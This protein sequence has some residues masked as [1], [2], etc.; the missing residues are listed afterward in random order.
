MNDGRQTDGDR[1]WPVRILTL[2]PDMITQAVSHSIIGRAGTAGLLDV[3]AVDIRDFT[4]DRHKTADDVPFGGGPGM[5]MK[6]EPLAGA[7]RAAKA[8]LPGAPVILMSASGRLF[9]QG[10]ARRFAG[11]PAGLIIVC[12]HYEGV[13]ERIAEFYC[14]EEICVGDYVLSGGEL[15]A[16]A[17][18]DAAARLI[19]GVLGNAD[20]LDE[21]SHD[22][23]CLEYPHYTRPRDFEGHQVPEVLFSGN[24]AAI[25]SFRRQQAA[26]KTARNR[27]DLARTNTEAP[28]ETEAPASGN[29]TA[30]AVPPGWGRPNEG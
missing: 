17:I 6:P 15:P 12:G 11:C 14:D 28:A 2:F 23:G 1:P 3:R 30:R 13:D 21:E 16:L 9:G 27:P 10:D 8:E 25:A 24:H 29:A 20:S 22:D 18:T 19:P 26:I 5:V 4:S 7:I